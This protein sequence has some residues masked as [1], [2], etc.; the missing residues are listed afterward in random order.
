MKSTKQITVTENL[1][2]YCGQPTIYAGQ[3]CIVC[4]K[5]V[6]QNCD[7]LLFLEVEGPR[8]LGLT[9]YAPEVSKCRACPTCKS[10]I[11][12]GMKK[13]GEYMEMWKNDH[14]Y[15]LERYRNLAKRIDALI[16]KR[17]REIEK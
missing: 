1:C 12:R 3:Y 9:Q 7:N 14:Q 16:G 2:D 17:E 15:H 10:E 11:T 4:G 6:C 5:H 8:F 13:L